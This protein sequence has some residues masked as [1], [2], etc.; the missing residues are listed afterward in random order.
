MATVYATTERKIVQI[1][2]QLISNLLNLIV[3][4]SVLLLL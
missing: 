3:M 1:K 4:N 2:P